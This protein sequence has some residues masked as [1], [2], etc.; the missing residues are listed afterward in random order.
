V[1]FARLREDAECAGS[2]SVNH[3]VCESDGREHED[4]A[5]VLL[6]GSDDSSGRK[7]PSMTEF[8][9]SVAVTAALCA[10]LA[11]AGCGSDPTRVS[12]Q[13][14]RA[15][16]V[17]SSR[18]AAPLASA[19][20]ARADLP[21]LM[22]GLVPRSERASLTANELRVHDCGIAPTFPCMSAFFSVADGL[23]VAVRLHRL[24]AQA[25]SQGW[26]VER[27][28]RQPNGIYIELVRGRVHARYALPRL[29][30]PGDSIVE[31]NVAGRPTALPTPSPAE[32]AA[33]SPDKRRYVRAVN[34]ICSRE[35]SHV[36]DPHQ[37]SAALTQASRSVTALPPPPGERAEV[38]TFLQPLRLMAQA[39]QASDRAKGEDV[40]PAVLAVAKY[41]IRFNKAATRYGLTACTLA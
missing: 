35:F 39:A 13:P 37:L 14:G 38:A 18:D 22:R 34:A 8:V 12:K 23:P 31:V 19:P 27:V 9:R 7:A 4:L 15:K 33:W 11:A 40:L 32:R 24:R 10:M 6:V 30:G 41:T 28:R 5:I 2:P 29:G 25:L 21:A 26:R 16:G 17:V 3:Q 36:S 20:T 1:T